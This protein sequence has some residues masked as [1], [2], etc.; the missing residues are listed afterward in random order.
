MPQRSHRTDEMAKIVAEEARAAGCTVIRSVVVN[1][2]VEFIRQLVS[3]V[4]NDNE[5]D[6]IVLVGGTGFGP[7]DSAVEALDGFLERQ[8]EGFAQSYR[9][10]LRDEMG[11][12][13]KSLLVRAMAGVYNKCVVFAMTGRSQD[14]RRAMQ[15]LVL[16]TLSDAIELANGRMRALEIGT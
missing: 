12:G 14:V 16:P 13:A 1:G 4:S 8:M 6:A 9:H 15:V 10:L 3:N 11:L 5:A 7:K 2:A